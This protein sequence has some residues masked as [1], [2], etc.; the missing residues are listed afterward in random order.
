MLELLEP[1]AHSQVKFECIN[2]KDSCCSRKVVALNAADIKRMSAAGIDVLKAIMFRPLEKGR[3]VKGNKV[4]GVLTLR[5]VNGSCMFLKD[6]LC[7]IHEHRPLACRLY[8]FNPIF[9]KMSKGWKT[10]FEVDSTCPSLK[11]LDGD[12]PQDVIKLA[13]QW[14][15][16]R[17]AYDLRVRKWNNREKRNLIEFVKRCLKE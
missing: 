10:R 2:C 1:H 16:E 13:K 3:V 4:S 5:Q 17:A 12:I 9:T 15:D 8:P 6:H 14:R 11:D 7:S